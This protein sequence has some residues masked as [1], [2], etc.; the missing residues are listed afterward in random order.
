MGKSIDECPCKA[1][2]K[3]YPYCRRCEEICNHWEKKYPY[4]R[5]C[6]EAH[7][8]YELDRFSYCRRCV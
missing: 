2:E 1:W 4:C 7:N 5:L 8:S 6:K 3:E